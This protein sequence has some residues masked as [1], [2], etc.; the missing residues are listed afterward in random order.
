MLSLQRVPM[1][2]L[3]FLHCLSMPLLLVMFN[4][5]LLLPS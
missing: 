3:H 2:L 5:P 1:S 4:L